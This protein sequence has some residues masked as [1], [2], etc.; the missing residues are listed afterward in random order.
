M[1]LPKQPRFIITGASTGIGKGLALALARKH[2]A[3][4]ILTART[5]SALEATK[6]QVEELGGQAVIIS[7]DLSQANNNIAQEL[8]ELATTT[9]GGL[10][11]IVNNA[12]MAIP[13][14]FKELSLEKWRLLFE[15]N[16]FSGLKLIQ[17]ALPILLAN[18]EGSRKIVNISSVAGKVAFPGSI[19]YCAT[20]FALT[21]LSEGLAAELYKDK[22]DVITVCPGW[23][24]T[25]FFE[26][27]AVPDIKNP[28]KIASI[29]SL[30]GFLMKNVLSIS[31]DDCVK[32]ILHA[33][34]GK[35]SQELVQT[36]PGKIF[37]RLHGVAPRL[38]QRIVR[39]I[40]NT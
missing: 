39:R 23:V 25:E 5:A 27:N 14:S 19:S 18:K 16:F 10:D 17:A 40:P 20:K 3:R 22:V 36:F 13:S 31:T 9:Y 28:T 32:D 37:E 4:L 15:V 34:E 26:K 7:A 21:A 30:P 6:T 33:L 2:K 35:G 38:A 29:G 11:G 1:T 24:R 8:V 12:G